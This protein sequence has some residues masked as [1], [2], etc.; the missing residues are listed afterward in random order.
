MKTVEIIGY[1]RA[2][3]GKQDSKR[4][5]VAG[6]VPC[7]VYGNGEQV[8]FYAP[9][10][11]FRELVYTHEAHFVQL[12]IG[13]KEF[14]CIMQDIQFHP[15][16]EMI[17]HIDFLELHVGKPV[18]MKIPVVFKGSAIGMLQGG[19]LEVKQQ[20]L[21]VEALPKDM[22]DVISVDITDLDLGKSIKVGDVE[23]ENFEFLTSD[24]VTIAS[25]NIPRVARMT[26]ELEEEEAEELEEGVEGV[27]GVEGAEGAETE[28]GEATAPGKSDEK[29]PEE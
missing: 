29:S 11:M 25:V 8:H 23:T 18:K 22:P 2:N 17:L 7:V 20:G 3:L 4:L 5:R 14:R 9:V 28:G 26:D 10:I 15:V 21:M 1:E 27:E 12:N 13:E 16:S 19:K 6:N 24:R